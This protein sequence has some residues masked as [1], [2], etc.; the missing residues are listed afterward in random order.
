MIN[1][2]F[3]ML[4]LVY[5]TLSISFG[6]NPT[7]SP[8]ITVSL[9]SGDQVTL[10]E[11]SDPGEKVLYFMPS[12]LTIKKRKGRPNFNAVVYR[13]LKEID[14]DQSLQD[15]YAGKLGGGVVDCILE[16]QGPT[17]DLEE[18]KA[19]IK[20]QYPKYSKYRLAQVPLVP[21]SASITMSHFPV[22]EH[23]TPQLAKLAT[24]Q[25]ELT[26][27]LNSGGPV[28]SQFGGVIPVRFRLS[29]IDALIMT[30]TLNNAISN[31]AFTAAFDVQ[32]SAKTRINFPATKVKLTA[33]KRKVYEYVENH[34][35]AKGGFFMF[36]FNTDIRKIRQ[37]LEEDGHL[38]ISI[39]KQHDYISFEFLNSLADKWVE[40][41]VLK[42]MHQTTLNLPKARA[43]AADP[44]LGYFN[45]FS[46]GASF[47][48]VKINQTID[49]KVSFEWTYKGVETLPIYASAEFTGLGPSNI[50]EVD[51]NDSYF[52]YG[53]FAVIPFTPDVMLDDLFGSAYI[54]F[55]IQSES[56]TVTKRTAS[57]NH[58][59]KQ[60]YQT[61][62]PLHFSAK[63]DN[64]SKVL[65]GKVLS[66]ITY[67]FSYRGP[68]ANFTLKN[69]KFDHSNWE[70]DVPSILI[71]K[72]VGHLNIELIAPDHLFQTF[73]NLRK[74]ELIIPA[75]NVE[76]EDI[77]YLLSSTSPKRS[78]FYDKR[79][80]HIDE[81]E[82]RATY[83]TDSGYLTRSS[84]KKIGQFLDRIEIDETEIPGLI[85]YGSLK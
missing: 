10:Y 20:K 85:G 32:F 29:E 69:Q 58:V 4:I 11:D 35:K 13:G 64:T 17:K 19:Y 39:D 18:L 7:L 6:G 79:N 5:T 9:P 40:N 27:K 44:K 60:V 70:F 36:S 31:D 71:A 43:Q 81:V 2:F 23:N 63:Q 1:R 62:F 57:F 24:D 67:N 41:Y 50:V 72:H 12:R 53:S 30:Q 26:R 52:S 54:S 76:S 38:N 15:S 46:L 48:R 42:E 66:D 47:S 16:L 78:Y 73:P 68:T 65:T 3:L 37:N 83:L 84:V 75:E 56:G 77:R 80:G 59:Q 28:S 55:E 74:V 34:F 82:I 25:K 61:F 49:K 45:W 14:I 51:Y 22:A 33:N 8:K 21:G